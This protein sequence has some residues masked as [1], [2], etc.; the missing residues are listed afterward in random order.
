MP[1]L[2]IIAERSWLIVCFYIMTGRAM[3]PGKESGNFSKGVLDKHLLPVIFL[4]FF[5][6]MN[7]GCQPNVSDTTIDLSW[8]TETHTPK[9]PDTSSLTHTPSLTKTSTLTPAHTVTV[10]TS[11]TPIPT[12]QGGGQ[13]KIATRNCRTGDFSV[14]CIKSIYTMNLDGSEFQL[15][16]DDPDP[17]NDF[18]FSPDGKY[19]AYR[20]GYMTMQKIKIANADG[21]H[22]RVVVEEINDYSPY[23]SWS[24]DSKA[25]A[26]VTKGDIYLFSIEDDRHTQLTDTEELLERNPQW[27]PDGEKI[28]FGAYRGKR[29]VIDH[30][31]MINKDGSELRQLPGTESISPNLILWSPDSLRITF[32]NGYIDLSDMSITF[33][34]GPQL[35]PGVKNCVM[36]PQTC[37]TYSPIYWSEDSSSLY[38]IGQFISTEVPSYIGKMIISTQEER[39]LF[40]VPDER[41]EINIVHWSP[42]GKW[43]LIML[44]DTKS[45]DYENYLYSIESGSL[46]RIEKTGIWIP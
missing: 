3:K 29:H 11:L 10:T 19:I 32:Y 13:G 42:D 8:P 6:F 16:I 35:Y 12:L 14:A 34:P 9:P 43:V 1:Y 23:F 33:L 7:H 45:N 46:T 5:A 40:E 44:R 15:L 27:S 26:Y 21:S 31:Y 25:M 20:V 24:P 38:F 4:L 2:H 41:K 18:S 28:A 22:S 39:L 37:F 17:I 36:D 30:L